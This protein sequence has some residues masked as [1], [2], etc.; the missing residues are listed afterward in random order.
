MVLERCERKRHYGIV[1]VWPVGTCAQALID[2]TPSLMMRSA[3]SDSSVQ[4]L[5]SNLANHSSDSG[6]L[7]V[8]TV[9]VRDRVRIR[10]KFRVGVWGLVWGQGY[11]QG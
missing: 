10:V 2:L 4:Y 7:C 8:R 6:R 5:H 1:M 9:R 11:S 3:M